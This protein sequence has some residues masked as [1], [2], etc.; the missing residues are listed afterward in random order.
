MG[1][2]WQVEGQAVPPALLVSF[3]WETSLSNGWL[4]YC[5]VCG[6]YTITIYNLSVLNFDFVCLFF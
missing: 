1:K 4:Q 3:L 2:R 6:V 5:L